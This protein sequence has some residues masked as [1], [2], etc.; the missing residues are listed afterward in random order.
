MW[1]SSLVGS[2]AADGVAQ[3]VYVVVHLFVVLL[4]I[5]P[6]TL[7]LQHWAL[8]VVIVVVVRGD[9]GDGSSSVGEGNLNVSGSVFGRVLS[10]VLNRFFPLCAHM[11][12]AARSMC[13]YTHIKAA[14]THL[15]PLVALVMLIVGFYHFPTCLSY[16]LTYTHAQMCA[17]NFFLVYFLA[18]A[19]FAATCWCM[20]HEK[21]LLLP[22]CN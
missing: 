20:Q 12:H 13:I 19:L 14:A 18:F 9:G 3:I 17:V 22:F 15:C 4:F 5:M 6:R 16:S 10:P 11:L 1:Q 8:L 7:L 2:A 21:Q